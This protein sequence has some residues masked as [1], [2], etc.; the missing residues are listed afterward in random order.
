V[1]NYGENYKGT[2]HQT[3]ESKWIILEEAI[4]VY[5]WKIHY[6]TATGSN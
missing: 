3:Y 6:V 1:C 4:W 5:L 2:Y